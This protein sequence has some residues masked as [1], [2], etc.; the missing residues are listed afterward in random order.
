[1][2]SMVEGAPLPPRQCAVPPPRFAGRDEFVARTI[3][4]PLSPGGRWEDGAA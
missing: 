3:F 2:R 4:F 1:M